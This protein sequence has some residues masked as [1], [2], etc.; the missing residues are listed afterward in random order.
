[1]SYCAYNSCAQVDEHW[2]NS[3]FIIILTGKRNKLK[4]LFLGALLKPFDFEV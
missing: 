4:K 1:M 2:G 3:A